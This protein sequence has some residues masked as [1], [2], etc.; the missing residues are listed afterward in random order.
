MNPGKPIAKC[1]LYNEGDEKNRSLLFE[2]SL[3]FYIKNSKKEFPVKQ[4][5][6]IEFKIKRL[7]APLIIGG[8]VA[9]LSLVALYQ[10][11]FNPWLLM[12]LFFS[13]VLLFYYGWSGMPSVSV[14]TTYGEY[15]ILVHTVSDNL[16]T[17]IKFVNDNLPLKNKEGFLLYLPISINVYNNLKENREIFSDHKKIKLLTKD[18]LYEMSEKERIKFPYIAIIDLRE[19]DKEIKYEKTGMEKDL[20]PY[21][22]GSVRMAYIKEI[23]PTKWIV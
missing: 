19:L 14:S 18:Q 15:N 12:I 22:S 5:L 10:Y 9:P 6:E 20:H 21:M 23:K 7:L 11:L 16:K 1:Y 13:G 3:I 17:Y 4:I 8:V 2:E